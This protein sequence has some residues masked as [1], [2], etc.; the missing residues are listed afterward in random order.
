MN[1]CGGTLFSRLDTILIVV[2]LV[3]QSFLLRLY[4]LISDKRKR[5]FVLVVDPEETA[6]LSL[7]FLSL[8]FVKLFVCIHF[9]KN[10]F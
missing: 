4:T 10:F 8:G 3:T 5:D 7:T 9:K 6:S 1:S 2:M